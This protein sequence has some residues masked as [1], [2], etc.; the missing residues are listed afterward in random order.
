MVFGFMKVLGLD[1]LNRVPLKGGF[2]I[3]R[4]KGILT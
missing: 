4:L 2:Y 1:D 3:R